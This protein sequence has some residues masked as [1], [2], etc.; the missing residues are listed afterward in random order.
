MGDNYIVCG[1]L[2]AH[3]ISWG[4]TTNSSDGNKLFDALLASGSTI[5]NNGQPTFFSARSNYS[6]AIDISFSNFV[7]SKVLHWNVLNHP[8]SSDHYAIEII[9]N[10]AIENHSTFYKAPCLYGHRTNWSKIKERLDTPSEDLLEIAQNTNLDV[11]SKYSTFIAVVTDCFHD[12]DYK[13]SKNAK[14][15]LHSTGCS[16]NEKINH[17]RNSHHI[18]KNHWWNQDCNKIIRL[19]KAAYQK[20]KYHYTLE[21]FLNYQKSVVL[22]KK[23]LKRIKKEA[24]KNFCGSL[25]KNTN[26]KYV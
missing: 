14:G 16:E 25:D 8:W 7:L 4:G 20:L 22:S 2:N 17:F 12:I 5:L 21:N 10:D 18:N 26:L 6:S 13:V 19:R 15:K 1:D 23:E 9:L 3:H 24:F 11:E